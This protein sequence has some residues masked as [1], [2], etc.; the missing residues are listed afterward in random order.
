VAIKKLNKPEYVKK[1][2]ILKRRIGIESEKA[3][4]QVNDLK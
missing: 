4:K 1:T 3:G 2:L